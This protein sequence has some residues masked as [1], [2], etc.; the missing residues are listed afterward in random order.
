[1]AQPRVA[2]RRRQQGWVMSLLAIA[3]LTLLAIVVVTGLGRFARDRL[4]AR[5]TNAVLDADG[6][7]IG[8]GVDWGACGELLLLCPDPGSDGLFALVG[9]RPNRITSRNQVFYAGADCT[10]AAYLAPPA[11]PAASGGV[12]PPDLPVGY[13]NG[14]LDLL[15]GTATPRIVYGVGAPSD[16]QAGCT[17]LDTP[18]ADGGRLY[19]RAAGAAGDVAST[20]IESVWT[21]LAPDC[22]PGGFGGATPAPIVVEYDFAANNGAPSLIQGGVD[23]MAAGLTMT[24]NNLPAVAAGAPG[25][26]QFGGAPASGCNCANALACV[27]D[28]RGS[29]GPFLATYYNYSFTGVADAT[30]TTG[31]VLTE[32]NP[33][34]PPI[35]NPPNDLRAVP[36]GSPVPGATV[37]NLS[38]NSASGTATA[39]T[40]TTLTHTALTGGTRAEPP[41]PN[42]W[43]SGDSYRVSGT[44]SYLQ[45]TVTCA[46]GGSLTGA[47]VSLNARR[48]SAQNQ[49]N[50]VLHVVGSTDGF[51]TVGADVSSGQLGQQLS[52]VYNFDLS[53]LPAA[54]AVGV[55]IHAERTGGSQTRLDAR[56]DNIRFTGSCAVA[57][58]GA[59]FTTQICLNTAQTLDLVPAVEVLNAGGAN[60]LSE[61][62]PLFEIR[63]AAVGTI[64][65]A[66]ESGAGTPIDPT[67]PPTP[68]GG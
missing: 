7:F 6:D 56:L 33:P 48:V 67:V 36:V 2:F 16:W 54:S 47:A 27:C 15:A 17:D 13:L 52:D 26:A 19:R 3:A 34:N 66:A 45:F 37:T 8:R 4:L 51:A 14:S 46:G 20:A 58:A 55:R 60:V 53:A 28:G 44:N 30:N 18:C 41:G 64:P 21:S 61:F 29:A 59:A 62:T 39:A 63:P 57:A 23:A 43:V 35:S 9:V 31:T 38:D 65:P 5:A 49:E 42:E 12:F 1:M 68:E 10:G 32:T 22:A 40:A 25:Y 11:V 50:G 24:A